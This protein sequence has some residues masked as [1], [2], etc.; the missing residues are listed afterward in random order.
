MDYVKLL[1]EA[2]KVDPQKRG[3]DI[4]G[5]KTAYVRVAVEHRESFRRACLRTGGVFIAEGP[6]AGCL[7]IGRGQA[8]IDKANGIEAHLKNAGVSCHVVLYEE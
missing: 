2:L 6:R 5:H 3:P 7:Y 4:T 1:G 8:Y